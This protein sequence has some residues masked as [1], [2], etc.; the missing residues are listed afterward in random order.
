MNWNEFSELPHTN[1]RIV[2]YLTAKVRLNTGF[3]R[4]SEKIHM[5]GRDDIYVSEAIKRGYKW[6]YENIIISEL[7]THTRLNNNLFS[8]LFHQE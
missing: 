7:N 6:N 4:D 2:V 1:S 8:N 5:N 3:L